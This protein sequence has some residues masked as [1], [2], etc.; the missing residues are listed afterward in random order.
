MPIEYNPKLTPRAREMRKD[1]TPQEK[2]LWHG[3]LRGHP[4][5]FRR[6]KAIYQYIVDFYCH[7]ARLVI[8]VDGCQH[9]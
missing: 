1:M 7:D 2:R 5:H 9:S 4:L 6:Q 8:E 3:Y